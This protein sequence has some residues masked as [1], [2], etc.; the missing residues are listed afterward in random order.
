MSGKHIAKKSTVIWVIPI[1]LVCLI[2][3]VAVGY[4]IAGGKETSDEGT[5]SLAG[6]ATVDSE[7]S[8]S[9]VAQADSTPEFITIST[10]YGDLYYP[11]QWNEFLVT[12][13]SKEG[14]SLIV[15][16]SAQINDVTYPMF[17]VTIGSSDD[18]EV[19]EL[20]DSS[21]TTRTVYM[22]VTEI[23]NVDELTDS[24]LRRLYAMQEDLNYLIDNLK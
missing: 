10:D 9:T 14:D 5:T 18:T 22:S 24:E 23:E 7:S 4:F 11:E 6:D 15:S 2:A 13:E 8:T 12:E 17:Q 16:F 19:G 1:I 3:G 21:G 20:V